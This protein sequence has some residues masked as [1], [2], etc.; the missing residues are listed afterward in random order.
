MLGLHKDLVKLCP[1]DPS[2][3]AEFEK[4]RKLLQGILG[5]YALDIQHVGSTSI[6]GLSAKPI[7]DIAVAVGNEEILYKLIPI[8]S[9]AG[10]DVKNSIENQGEILARKGNP[11]RRTHYIHV[12]IKDGIYWG[13]HITFRDYLITHPEYIKKYEDLKMNASA[14]IKDRKTYTA[15]KNQFIQEVLQLARNEICRLGKI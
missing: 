9:R 14:Q 12:E 3:K 4:E 7:V 15:Y 1:Y 13:N 5:D 11:E 2:W 8:L 6:P 10:Y